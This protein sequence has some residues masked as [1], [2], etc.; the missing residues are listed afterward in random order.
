MATEYNKDT[1]YSLIYGENNNI[2]SMCRIIYNN[3]E[4][5]INM[6]YVNPKYRGL[7]ICQIHMQHIINIHKN[8]TNTFV[9]NVENTNIPAIKCYQAIGFKIMRK[10]L[11]R[12]NK[13]HT[14]NTLNKVIKSAKK[15]IIYMR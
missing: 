6:V 11:H 12:N 5:Y 14:Y 13:F 9:L 4:G 1:K 8:I 15:Q 10:V 2:I 7:K 3:E